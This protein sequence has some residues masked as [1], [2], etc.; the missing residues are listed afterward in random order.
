MC[1]TSVLADVG[2]VGCRVKG[3]AEIGGGVYGVDKYKV[4]SRMEREAKLARVTMLYSNNYWSS[5]GIPRGR[6]LISMAHRAAESSRR[7]VHPLC[8]DRST[9]RPFSPSLTRY[10][11]LFLLPSLPAATLLSTLRQAN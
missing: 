6:G 11:F 7:R 4:Q 9:G 2:G 1:R 10:A 3:A 5:I 8:P